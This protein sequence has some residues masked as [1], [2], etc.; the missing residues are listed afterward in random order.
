M[1]V[2]DGYYSTVLGDG[3]C[4]LSALD[5]QETTYWSGV[6][7][8]S[9]GTEMLPRTELHAVPMA[10]ASQSAP[11]SDGGPISPDFTTSERNGLGDLVPGQIIYNSTLGEL[12]MYTGTDWVRIGADASST[13]ASSVIVGWGRGTTGELGNGSTTTDNLYVLE[14]T[15][16]LDPVVIS[17]GGYTHG[18]QG[19][20]CL[21]RADNTLWCA[22]RGSFI[23]DGV[24]ANQTSFVQGG[25]GQLGDGTT[26]ER[27]TPVPVLG[28]RRFKEISS[29]QI[30]TCAI[31]TSDT[32]WCW[33]DNSD[34]VIGDGS[35]TDRRVPTR[36]YGEY[37]FADI[38]LGYRHILGRTR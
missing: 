38:D 6:R 19:A 30:N 2:V 34:G 9:P 4:D 27:Q 15:D 37:R 1:S 22:G 8:G 18:A 28:G 3:G 5:W 35:T 33:G 24:S 29:G 7:V 36:V 32:L 20:S 21:V 26:T 25:N 16:N 12:Q 17:G 14:L 11:N 10:I 13:D 23:P 31:D